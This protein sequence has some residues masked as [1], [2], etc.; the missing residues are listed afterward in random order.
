MGG[1]DITSTAYNNNIITI[2]SVTGNVTISIIAKNPDV[3]NQIPVSTDTEGL[4]YNNKGY[5]E[6]TYISSDPGG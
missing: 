2:E 4:I 3:I 6:N 1:V 5:K